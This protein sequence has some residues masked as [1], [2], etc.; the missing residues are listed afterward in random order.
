[1]RAWCIR[2]YG[3]PE[4]MALESV[5]MPDPGP[6][7]ILI[8]VRAASVNPIDWKMRC[9]LLAG[10]FPV[11]FPRTLGRDCAGEVVACGADVTGFTSGTLVAGVAD[12]R[13][14]GT[15]AEFAV[16]PAAQAAPVPDGLDASAAASL[17]VAGLSAAIALVEI[18]QVG[19]GQRVLVHAGAGGVGSL[20]IQL[21]RHLGAE[22]LATASAANRDYCAGLGA[23]RVI[24]YRAAD[25]VAAAA[26]CDVVLDTLGGE[27]HLR[28]LRALRPGGL[29]VALSAAPI[30]PGPRRA[31]VRVAAAQVQPTRDRLARIFEWAVTG[32]L[33]PQVGRTFAFADAPQAYAA[34]EAG[35][36]RGKLVVTVP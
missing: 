5:A 15:H 4:V 12:A 23:A 19:H 16:L 2:A 33:R 21:G 17:C 1:M 29:L 9:G 10:V 27:H 22:V 34:S 26:P 36:A 24:D 35:H 28:S 14:H 20:A 13:A 8:R 3:G 18:A 6:D 25:F 7:E 31:D 30:P 32:V 11:A